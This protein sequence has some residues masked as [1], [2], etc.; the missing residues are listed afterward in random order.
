MKHIVK[1]FLPRRLFT[2]AKGIIEYRA[3]RAWYIK[4]AGPD[5][6]EST[7]AMAAIHL[8]MQLTK[9]YHRIEK[10]L[11]LP[12]PRQPFGDAVASRIDKLLPTA[13]QLASHAP[14][15]SY[16]NSA[17]L[18]LDEWNKTGAISSATTPIGSPTTDGFSDIQNFFKSRHSVRNF[19]SRKV[20]RELLDLATALAINTPS[21]C[22]RQSWRLRLFDSRQDIDAALKYQNG[23]S[24]FGHTVPALALITTEVGLFA[25]VNERNQVWIEGGLFAMSLCWALHGL[26]LSSCMLNM[27]QR[28]ERHK[29]LKQRFGIPESEAVIMFMAI[30]YPAEGFRVAR[31]PRRDLQSVI[32]YYSSS[33]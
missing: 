10:G 23:N 3:D 30:G 28:H 14:F 13:N 21:V 16:A 9:D 7:T 27:S 4:H 22:N 2:W 32:H 24:G 25:G 33:V 5:D 19:D 6:D 8:E 20:P 11:A 17:R 18:A 26:G 29:R 15:V 1:S 31:S 12:N